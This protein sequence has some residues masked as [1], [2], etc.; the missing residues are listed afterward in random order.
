VAKLMLFVEIWEEKLGRNCQMN[1][2]KLKKE[3]KE[4]QRNLLALKLIMI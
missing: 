1:L 3:K 4:K 2:G